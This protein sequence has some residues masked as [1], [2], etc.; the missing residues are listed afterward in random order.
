MIRF[1]RLFLLRGIYV[2]LECEAF[3]ELLSCVE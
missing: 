1:N 3:T 2:Q